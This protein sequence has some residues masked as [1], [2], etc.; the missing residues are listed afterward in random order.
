MADVIWY[1]L[2]YFWAHGDDCAL[3]GPCSSRCPEYG[4]VET[5]RSPEALP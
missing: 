4:D 3:L 1:S 5:P 2:R